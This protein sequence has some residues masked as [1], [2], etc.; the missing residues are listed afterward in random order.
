MS[1]AVRVDR[2]S[3]F[4]DEDNFG[5]FYANK[6]YFLGFASRKFIFHCRHSKR[7]G[8]VLNEMFMTFEHVALLLLSL[9]SW[10]E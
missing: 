6:T 9:T 3:D 1:F 10:G 4:A 8:N 5:A 7:V 2:K